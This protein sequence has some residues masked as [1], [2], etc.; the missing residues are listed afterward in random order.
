MDR[1]H[2][3]CVQLL[4]AVSK[5]NAEA[6]GRMIDTARGQGYTFRSLEE[7]TA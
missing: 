4:H 2:P 1:L 7:Y 6:L 3:G 5:D